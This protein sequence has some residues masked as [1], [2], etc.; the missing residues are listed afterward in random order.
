M[1]K[2]SDLATYHR[3]YKVSVSRSHLKFIFLFYK[4]QNVSFTHSFTHSL[5]QSVSHQ[6]VSSNRLILS[7]LIKTITLV[8]LLMVLTW[9]LTS[10]SRFSNFVGKIFTTDRNLPE[11]PSEYQIRVWVEPCSPKSL[12]VYSYVLSKTCKP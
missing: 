10:G 7:E 11:S 4:D 5:S 1:R 9:N 12:K 2:R 3:F 6:K 8:T